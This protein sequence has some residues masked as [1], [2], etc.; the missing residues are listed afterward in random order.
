MVYTDSPHRLTTRTPPAHHPHTTSP[1]K[2]DEIRHT[3]TSRVVG[4]DMDQVEG[5][6][7]LDAYR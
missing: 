3:S 1:I 5:V 2:F 6:D 4:K 7:I